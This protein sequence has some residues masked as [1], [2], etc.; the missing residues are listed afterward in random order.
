MQRPRRPKLQLAEAQSTQVQAGPP[1]AHEQAQPP[2]RQVQA[3]P[4]LARVH[5]QVQVQPPRPA[6]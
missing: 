6:P 4:P 1:Q 3:E 5:A 2:Q